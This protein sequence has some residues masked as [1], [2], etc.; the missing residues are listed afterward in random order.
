MMSPQDADI[1]L[2]KVDDSTKADII[3]YLTKKK[4]EYE[5]WDCAWKMKKWGFANFS[6]FLAS[7]TTQLIIEPDDDLDNIQTIRLQP[8]GTVYF[9]KNPEIRG[10][11][12]PYFKLPGVMKVTRRVPTKK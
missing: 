12:M 4:S 7:D 5:K 10:Y 3:V 6:V 9:T 8:D 1:I 11:R 2:L